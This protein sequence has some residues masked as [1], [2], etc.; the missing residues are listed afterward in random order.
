MSLKIRNIIII[1]NAIRTKLF[2]LC[3]GFSHG[4]RIKGFLATRLP[5]KPVEMVKAMLFSSDKWRR[6]GKALGEDGSL[7][8]GGDIEER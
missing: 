8:H 4:G 6:E 2:G 3:R 7:R 1:I 5:L